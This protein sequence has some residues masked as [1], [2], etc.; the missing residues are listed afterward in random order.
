[1]IGNLLDH[2][3]LYSLEQRIM[4]DA[5]YHGFFQLYVAISWMLHPV[6]CCFCDASLWEL[7]EL[8]LKRLIFSECRHLQLA[9][10]GEV[11][12]MIMTYVKR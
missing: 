2:V 9:G 1:M 5:R 7:F 8:T 12:S 3:H 10:L 6:A 11:V 4:N